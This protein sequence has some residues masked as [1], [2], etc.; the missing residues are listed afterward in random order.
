MNQANE[1]ACLWLPMLYGYG[2]FSQ[3][4]ILESD[5]DTWIFD[6]YLQLQHS[7][8]M[9]PKIIRYPKHIKNFQKC[10]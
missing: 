7:S 5:T 8:I 10:I 2:Y 4:D 1:F 9:Y 6:E 3:G